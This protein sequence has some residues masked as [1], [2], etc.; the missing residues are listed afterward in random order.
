M[1][2]VVLRARA[3]IHRRV[4]AFRGAL[5]PRTVLCCVS[6]LWMWRLDGQTEPQRRIF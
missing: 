3:V 5:V 2:R 1:P 4:P 6:S